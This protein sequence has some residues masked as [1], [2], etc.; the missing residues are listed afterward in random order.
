MAGQTYVPEKVAISAL[1]WPH[2]RGTAA[3]AWPGSYRLGAPG[4]GYH[5]RDRHAVL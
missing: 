1:G 3:P 5:A 2:A 4:C